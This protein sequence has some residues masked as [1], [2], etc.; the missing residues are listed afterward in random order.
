TRAPARRLHPRRRRRDLRQ[1]LQPASPVDGARQTG[2]ARDAPAVGAG[3]L[4][5]R[6]PGIRARG[7][8]RP[9]RGTHGRAAALSRAM[10]PRSL[11]LV[12][13][14]L[15]SSVRIG[16]AARDP[17]PSFAPMLREVERAVV[18]IATVARAEDGD[19]GDP[20]TMQELLRRFS[21]D[22][23]RTGRSLGS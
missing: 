21:D 8:A 13:L 19:E 6:R 7:D 5:A 20:T 12:G 1:L 10:R 23:P 15:A 11:L 9:R 18:N 14:V 17:L 16:D 3:G 22:A 4:P 2:P